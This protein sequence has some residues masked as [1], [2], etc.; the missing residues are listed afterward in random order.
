MCVDILKKGIQL[1]AR[2]LH[3]ACEGLSCGPWAS[4]KLLLSPC[5]DRNCIRSLWPLPFFHQLQLPVPGPG[6]GAVW[7]STSWRGE[8]DPGV[9]LVGGTAVGE[10]STQAH[11]G[12]VRS[13]HPYSM[14]PRVYLAQPG[15]AQRH[16]APV[17]PGYRVCGPQC[18]R[19]WAS[20]L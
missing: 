10:T 6:V 5:L 2:E 15:A 17:G 8:G 1:A 18:H 20:L 9:V 3:V 14:Q 12:T 19:S 11:G 7:C 16:A 4:A 13:V